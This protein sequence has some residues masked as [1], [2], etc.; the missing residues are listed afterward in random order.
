[1]INWLQQSASYNSIIGYIE[2][3][4]LQLMELP[5]SK[6]SIKYAKKLYSFDKTYVK[7]HIFINTII[8]NRKGTW[9]IEKKLL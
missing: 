9:Y 7:A 8:E 3:Q 6:R 5:I 4:W 2:F 1:M